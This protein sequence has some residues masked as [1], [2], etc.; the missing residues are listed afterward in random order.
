MNLGFFGDIKPARFEG[1]KSENPFAYRHYDAVARR[2]GQDD[3]RA[4]APRRLLLA[5]FRL[6]RHRHVRR[7]RP[8]SGRGTAR[9]WRARASRPT[10]PSRC[11]RRSTCRS[12]PSTT[13]TSRPRARA[14]PNSA[15][16]SR[17][18]TDVFAEKM[19][20]TRRQAAVGHGQPV[21]PSAL[22]GGRRDQPRSRRVRL[23]RRAGEE[24]ARRD[25]QARRRRTTCC[26]AAARAT[27][28]CSTPT[29]SASS[30][31]S[32]ASCRWWSSTSTRSA[33]R[34]RILIEPKPQEPTKHQYDY[35]VATVFG[36]LQ[37]F[38]LEKEVKVNIEVGHAD[39]RRHIPSSTRSRLRPRSASRLGRR[40][41]RRPAVGLGH[42]PVPEQRRR[43][44]AGAL[45]RS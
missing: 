44:V 3:G 33:S 18:I 23:R 42:R 12:S 20:A 13:A 25:A 32:A 7:R 6:A 11:S 43:A 10:S 45:L 39:A 27:R 22:H 17:A 2:H 30:T 35:D 8:S 9:R 36:F 34:A 24:R 21:Q 1:E 31:S 38:G 4:A 16:T 15:T 37:R 29:S 14:S 19:Q 26:G 40:Q 28:R 41:P 5:Q